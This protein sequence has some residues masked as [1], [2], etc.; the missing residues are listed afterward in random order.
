MKIVTLNLDD[1]DYARLA[2]EAETLGLSLEEMMRG[3]LLGE[4]AA[5]AALGAVLRPRIDGAEQ[6]VTGRSVTEVAA[7]ARA[8]FKA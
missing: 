6:R 4:E 7:L 2:A 3:R 1:A 5:V 8:G